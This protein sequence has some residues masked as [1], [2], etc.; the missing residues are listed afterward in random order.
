MMFSH[1][2]VK[3]V[4]RSLEGDYADTGMFSTNAKRKLR[5]DY[6]KES[7]LFAFEVSTIEGPVVRVMTPAYSRLHKRTPIRIKL[8]D[9]VTGS[10]FHIRT[11]KCHTSDQLKINKMLA[12]T[13]KQCTEHLLA[14]STEK[15]SL[16]NEPD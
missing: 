7:T 14:I 11:G 2:D 5:M 8:M 3:K 6:L 4:R 13:Q 12:Y 16:N 1:K 9:V 10:F 15:A